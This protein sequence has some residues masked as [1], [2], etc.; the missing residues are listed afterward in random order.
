MC[1]P[2][3]LLNSVIFRKL[4]MVS[5]VNVA[6]I[7]LPFSQ[8]QSRDVYLI[9]LIGQVMPEPTL[10]LYR[11]LHGHGHVTIRFAVKGTNHTS[12]VRMHKSHSTQESI[13]MPDLITLPEIY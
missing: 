1:T 2:F 8:I 9:E 13:K 12:R 5:V 7:L 3:I 6:K 10:P 11:H 4:Q